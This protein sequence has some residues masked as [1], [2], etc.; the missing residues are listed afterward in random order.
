MSLLSY[1]TP[2]DMSSMIALKCTHVLFVGNGAQENQQS[3]VS[4]ALADCITYNCT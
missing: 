1:S 2:L 3:I 4:V